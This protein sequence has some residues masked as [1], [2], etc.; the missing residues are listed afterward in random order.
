MCKILISLA[1][2]L[3]MN[4]GRGLSQPEP[5]LG[6]KKKK[7][8]VGKIFKKK[9]KKKDLGPLYQNDLGPPYFHEPSYPSQ[10]SM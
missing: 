3:G 7:N 4:L 10:Q 6:P 1:S 9:K 8:L 2:W 5:P